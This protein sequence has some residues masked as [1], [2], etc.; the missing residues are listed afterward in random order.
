MHLSMVGIGVR[1]MPNALV[2]VLVQ[3]RTP[4]AS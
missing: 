3:G 4:K 2:F 1:V